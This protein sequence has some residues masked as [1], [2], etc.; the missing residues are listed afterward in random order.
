MNKKIFSLLMA[1]ALLAGMVFQVTP[2]QAAPPS[3]LAADLIT[4]F[5]ENPAHRVFSEGLRE[6][7]EHQSR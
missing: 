7:M 1:L 5:A 4:A 3:A 2:A 6:K